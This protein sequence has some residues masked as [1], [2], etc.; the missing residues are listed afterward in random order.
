MDGPRSSGERPTS[1]VTTPGKPYS[2]PSLNRPF[3]VRPGGRT[4]Q[5]APPAKY[6]HHRAV[7]RTEL[8]RRLGDRLISKLKRASEVESLSLQDSEYGQPDSGQVLDTANK[9]LDLLSEDDKESDI[10]EK[11]KAIP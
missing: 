9:L 1:P 4:V 3:S 11:N 2:V 7:L 8:S 6:L 5:P 10:I